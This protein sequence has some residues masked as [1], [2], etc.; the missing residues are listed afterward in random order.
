M[1]FRKRTC[2]TQDSSAR[3]GQ[4]S[5][6]ALTPLTKLEFTFIFKKLVKYNILI[7]MESQNTVQLNS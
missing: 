5:N 3:V 4:C 6:S 1:S 2:Q 7:V